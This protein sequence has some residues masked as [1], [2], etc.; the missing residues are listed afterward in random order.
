MSEPSGRADDLGDPAQFRLI[1][2]AEGLHEAVAQHFRGFVFGEGKELAQRGAHAQGNQFE[3]IKTGVVNPALKSRQM[4]G[5]DVCHVGQ[6]LLCHANLFAKFLD[7]ESQLLSR[8]HPSP[9]MSGQI[10][11]REASFNTTPN[12]AI[13]CKYHR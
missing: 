5:G 10:S 6:R 12:I 9:C 1:H 3:G 2:D 7:A 11:H 4:A 8:I 13:D